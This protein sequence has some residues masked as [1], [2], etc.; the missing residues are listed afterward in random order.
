M[1]DQ[2]LEWSPF[3][4]KPGVDE[5]TLVEASERLQRDFLAHQDG[6]VRRELVNGAEGA[7]VDMVWWTSFA[8]SQAAMKKAAASPACT[9]YVAL[10]DCSGRDPGD[11]VLLFGIVKT[12]RPAARFLALAI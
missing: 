11:D 5:A 4:L 1:T 10:M 7:Y 3:R 9:A 6:F 2:V 8:A 12:Y